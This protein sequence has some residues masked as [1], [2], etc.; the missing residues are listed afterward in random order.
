ML[1][2]YIYI[3]IFIGSLTVL[4]WSGSLLVKSIMKVTRYLGW[5]E[6]VVAFLVM[7]FA[8][9]L[10]NLFVG[11]NSAIHQIPQLSLGDVLG[12]NL[13][14]LTLI[15][16]LAILVSGAT[17]PTN[18]RM[19][20]TSAIFTIIVA[21]LPLIL[22]LDGTLGRGDG[23]ILLLCFF[24]YIFWI[25]S[26]EERFKK[27][28]N[29][30]DEEIEIIKDLKEFTKNLVI[31]ALSLIL[32]LG[33]SEGVVLTVR[34]FV[35]NFNLPL[36]LIAILVVGLGNA[37][38]EGYFAIVSAKKGQTWMI[39]GDLMGSVIVPSTL[40]LGIVALIHPIRVFNFSP[41]AIARIFLIL[42]AFLFLIVIRSGQKITKKEAWFLIFLYVI[43][44][45]VE[46]MIGL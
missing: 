16:A 14:V 13:V 39:L 37:L 19:V 30:E 7:A 43:F 36:E 5:R 4:F 42:A 8:S 17:L 15:I 46:I 18:S 20:Q 35:S 3:A 33:A 34:F 23:L 25:F 27:I 31:M 29:H 32:L 21:I 24:G 10:P 12:G 26:K 1:P 38:P 6:F 22:L 28:Y 9:S 41:F 11:I 2:A 44:V 40:V 45:V